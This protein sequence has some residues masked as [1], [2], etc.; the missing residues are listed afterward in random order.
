M[1]ITKYEQ[2]EM[3]VTPSL[4]HPTYCNLVLFFIFFSS[5]LGE[6]SSDAFGWVSFDFLLLTNCENDGIGG[7]LVSGEALCKGKALTEVSDSILPQCCSPIIVSSLW[8]NIVDAVK[9]D[10]SLHVMFS[11]GEVAMI[12]I[13][14]FISAELVVDSHLTVLATCE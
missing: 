3:E 6:C 4:G 13:R 7:S 2:N 9:G 14:F 8:W 5:F 12:P 11:E 10:S 1:I